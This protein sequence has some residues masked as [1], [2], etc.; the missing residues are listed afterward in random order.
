MSSPAQN[1][2]AGAGEDRDF[3][4]VAVAEFGPGFR[5][6]GA[7]FNVEGVE[8]LRAVHPDDQDLAVAFGF[9]DG[10]GAAPVGGRQSSREA[11]R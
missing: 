3:Q 11:A 1:P 10:H 2:A 8:R 7:H 5:E 4:F 6:Q 9:D